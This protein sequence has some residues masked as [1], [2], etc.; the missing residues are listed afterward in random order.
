MSFFLMNQAKLSKVKSPPAEPM[1][2]GQMHYRPPPNVV[3]D[4]IP[5]I[6]PQFVLGAF[7]PVLNAGHL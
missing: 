3:P 4:L 5:L 7:I 6:H 1:E 2:C